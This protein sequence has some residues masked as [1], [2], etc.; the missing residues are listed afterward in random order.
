[1]AAHQHTRQ[2]GAAT[3]RSEQGVNTQS[4]TD[5]LL[6]LCMCVCVPRLWTCERLDLVFFCYLFLLS[7]SKCLSTSINITLYKVCRWSAQICR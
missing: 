2:G 6:L 5:K 3:R 4:N 1:M 7:E